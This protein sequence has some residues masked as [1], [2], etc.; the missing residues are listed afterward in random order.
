[1]KSMI[2]LVTGPAKTNVLEIVNVL[3]DK[4]VTF[5]DDTGN[6]FILAPGETKTMVE[7]LKPKILS[8]TKEISKENIRHFQVEGDEAPFSFAVVDKVG[9]ISA[10][11]TS[12]D[13]Y[14]IYDNALTYLS[15]AKIKNGQNVRLR[16]VL[17]EEQ[18][19]WV[20]GDLID[21]I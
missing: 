15:W 12:P 11:G 17:D 3:P 9:I 5:I 20:V 16:V 6:S 7:G 13:D 10:L 2:E 21:N 19:V 4:S 14:K 8:S 1:M 18:V